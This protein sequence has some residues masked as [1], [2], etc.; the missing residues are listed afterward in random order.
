LLYAIITVVLVAFAAYQAVIQ[1]MPLTSPYV[2]APAIGAIWFALRLFMI[3]SAN[4][5]G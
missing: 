1:L 2:I 5:R 4:A 3:W